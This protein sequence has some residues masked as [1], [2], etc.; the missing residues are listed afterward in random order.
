MNNHQPEASTSTSTPPSKHYCSLVIDPGLPR[1]QYLKLIEAEGVVHSLVQR[2]LEK[3]GGDKNVR[4]HFSY[5]SER[6]ADQKLLFDAQVISKIEGYGLSTT[7]PPNTGFRQSSAFLASLP[8]LSRFLVTSG[9]GS[10]TWPGFSDTNTRNQ[11]PWE[12]S[13]FTHRRRET[14]LLNGIVEGVEESCHFHTTK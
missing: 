10:I 12:T 13:K 2:L 3:H 6:S 5:C 4:L 9:D 11:M 8:S 1:E 7:R 14:C